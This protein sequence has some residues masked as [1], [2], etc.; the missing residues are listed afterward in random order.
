MKT[1]RD[2]LLARHRAA[3]PKLDAIR[4]AVLAKAASAPAP[5][6]PDPRPSRAGAFAL[7]LTLW[8]E[9]ILPNRR[10]WSGLAATW[11]LIALIN[12]AESRGSQGTTAKPT[13]Q[14][15]MAAGFIEQQKLLGELLTERAPVTEA[16]RPKT[17]TPKP[18]TEATGLKMV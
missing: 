10:A 5:N 7:G 13:A 11:M 6:Q 2:I 14:S 3:E 9:L 18:H 12:L 8:R 4:K 1:P 17:F 15:N 16:D